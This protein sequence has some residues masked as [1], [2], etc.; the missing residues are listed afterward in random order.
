MT[1]KRNSSDSRRPGHGD[2]IPE[3]ADYRIV[4]AG[5]GEDAVECECGWRSEGYH[6]MTSYAYHDWLQHVADAKTGKM[7]P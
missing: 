1:D 7:S 6:D 4:P 5:A 3:H 2:G